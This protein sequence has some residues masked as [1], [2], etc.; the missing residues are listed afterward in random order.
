MM[1]ILVVDDQSDARLI[2]KK[3]LQQRNFDVL[4]AENGQQALLLIA[5]NRPDLIISDIMM[6]EMDG[7]EL[8]KHLKSDAQ[9]AEIPFIFYSAHFVDNQD[10]ALGKGLKAAGFLVKPMQSKQFLESIERVINSTETLKDRL[11]EQ[12][13]KRLSDQAFD[14][15]H[16]KRLLSTLQN[17]IE[18]IEQSEKRFKHVIQSIPSAV[19]EADAISL[20]R[21]YY[22]DVVY[23]LTGKTRD[24]LNQHRP[25]WFELIQSDY[26][27]N[28]KDSLIKHIKG[29]KD[30]FILEYPLIHENG[31]RLI[32]VEDRGG[33]E[34][35]ASGQTVKLYGA[36]SDISLRKQAE[37]KLQESF[38]AT[39]TSVSKALEKRDPY[40]A[41]HQD[42]CALIAKAIAEE[43]QLDGEFIKGLELAAKVHDI[44]KIYLPAEILNK[45]VKLSPA[46]RGLIET[47]SQ[48]GYE[49][50]QHV[51]FPWPIA[52]IILQHHERID[53]SGYPNGL[54]G[55][56]IL[57]EAKIL[58]VAD[59]IDA[60]ASDRPYRK[61]LG[62]EVAMEELNKNK[63]TLY[64]AEIA[65]V[66]LSLYQ[67]QRIPFLLN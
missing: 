17:K 48:V 61:S 15:E 49:I 64:D 20:E 14:S 56:N 10:I 36:V 44:G 28:I 59:I 62:L 26:R 40:T 31:D 63:S 5:G 43:M 55:D 23:D 57:L 8:C 35:D 58:S 67:Q 13:D 12:K 6:P 32:W 52:E 42:N 30:Q 46:E 47:H 50:I 2:Q 33:I 4:E 22:C 41:G 9:T 18:K 25:H 38:E 29:N 3:I 45:P 19:Y 37:Q 65:D 51:Q 1:K 60:M 39:I 54:K 24:D 16:K 7:F 34:R 66:C 53:G 27:Q 21:F 11:P